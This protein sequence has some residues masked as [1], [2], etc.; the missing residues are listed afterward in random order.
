MANNRELDFVLVSILNLRELHRGGDQILAE[1]DPA[2]K[3]TGWE[4]DSYKA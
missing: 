1:P 3:L 4:S 2:Y